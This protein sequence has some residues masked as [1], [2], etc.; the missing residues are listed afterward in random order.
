MSAQPA[1]LDHDRRVKAIP[2]TPDAIGES[3]SGA[4]R[5]AFYRE[6][7]R[8]EQGEQIDS[9]LD[10]WWMEALLDQVPGREERYANV[11]AGRN[12]VSLEDLAARCPGVGE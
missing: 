4:Q 1:H 10:K 9:V 8:A 6:L 3:L 12:L 2:R 5:M 11:M 7:G